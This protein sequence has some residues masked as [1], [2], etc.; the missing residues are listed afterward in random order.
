MLEP[1]HA[2]AATPEW[3]VH[4]A[5]IT[6]AHPMKIGLNLFLFKTRCKR[7]WHGPPALQELGRRGGN[8]LFALS[9]HVERLRPALD[10][11]AID[12]DLVDAVE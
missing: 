1:P 8:A 12:H 10:D 4:G 6:D 11:L 3:A 2:V 9:V 5:R 7:R